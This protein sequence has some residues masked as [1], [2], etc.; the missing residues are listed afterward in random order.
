MSPEEKAQLERTL[1]LSE[2]NN[3]LLLKM[4]RAARWAMFWGFIKIVVIVG[5]L[6]V[7]YIYLQPFFGQALENYNNM[8]ELLSR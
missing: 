3:R 7:G 4:H 2:E 8:K 1:K 6:I 5:P